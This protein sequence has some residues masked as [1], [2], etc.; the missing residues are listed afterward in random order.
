M[1][2]LQRSCRG[3]LRLPETTRRR[4]SG[5]YSLGEAP[6][7]FIRPVIFAGIVRQLLDSFPRRR[8][9]SGREDVQRLVAEL[10]RDGVAIMEDVA[11]RE[12]L[13][14]ARLDI[15][16]MAE[17]MPALEGTTRVKPAS[18]GGTRRYPVHEYQRELGIYRSHD[19]LVFSPAFAGFLLL[20]EV[21]EVAAGYLGR[22]W[23]YQAMIATRTEPGEGVREGFAKW[24]HDARGRKLN[25]FLLLSD[26]P[27]DGPATVVLKGSHRVVYSRRRREKNFFSDDEVDV[28]QRRHG[29]E[30]KVCSAPAGSILSIW[31]F[32]IAGILAFAIALL[33][34]SFH[35]V[36][37]ART[38]P[39]DALRYE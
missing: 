5:V 33:T 14:Q 36:K 11:S 6:L 10:D 2:R 39:A 18:T 24:H 27:E 4:I 1:T 16:L 19:P 8:P 13:E 22:A 29:W 7:L 23:L 34:V 35:A 38:D 15:E 9:V 32:L 28:L 21:V 3:T 26:V 17:K 37:A 31:V 30:I 20:P 12:L 25:I